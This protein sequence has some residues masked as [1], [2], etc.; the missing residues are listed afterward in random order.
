MKTQKKS[1]LLPLTHAALIAAV[2]VVLTLLAAGFGLAGGAIQ[3]RFSEALT[4][5]PFFTHAA[6]PGLTI[7]CLLANLLT[8]APWPDVVFGTF[9]TFLGA[10][11][12]YYLRKNRFLVS[13]PPIAAN[14]LIIPFVL[15]YAYGI[16]GSLFYFAATVGAGEIIC[17]LLFGQ[18][19]I[20]A[21]LPFRK[22]IFPES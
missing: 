21:L 13:L 17:C 7:G 20:S 22:T 2:Y 8:G 18:L 19:L 3:V 16:P 5:L 4:V 15:K 11:G 1:E 12:S 10:L 6:V 9:A 14:A